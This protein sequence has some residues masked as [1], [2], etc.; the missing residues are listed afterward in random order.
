MV[1]TEKFTDGS[2]FST[3]NVF[4]DL[5][6]NGISVLFRTTD[7]VVIHVNTDESFQ[8]R[9]P[10]TGTTTR[11]DLETFTFEFILGVLFPISTC[12]RVTI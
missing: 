12:V 10:E 2:R 7:F 3:F 1:A 11:N 4:S 6:P 5:G 8:F 9:V